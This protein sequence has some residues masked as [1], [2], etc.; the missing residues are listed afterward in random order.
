MGIAKFEAEHRQRLEKEEEQKR[1]AEQK[2]AEVRAV[3]A[4]VFV[5]SGNEG[6]QFQ[7][8]RRGGPVNL[9]VPHVACQ[10]CAKRDGG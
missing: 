4:F 8:R 7:E 5:V 2:R 10:G 9:E 6:S 3:R 1:L